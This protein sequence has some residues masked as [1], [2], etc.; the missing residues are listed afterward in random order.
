MRRLLAAVAA[1]AALLA[2]GVIRGAA[3]SPEPS[4]S[5][6]TTSSAAAPAAAATT[7]PVAPTS[8]TSSPASTGASTTPTPTPTPVEFPEGAP[9]PAAGDLTA[10]AVATAEMYVHAWSGTAGVTRQQWLDRQAPYT[11]P[12]F[13][14]RLATVD[15]ANVPAT[16]ITGPSA[17]AHVDDHFATVLVPTDGGRVAVAL[18]AVPPVWQV[19]GIEPAPAP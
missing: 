17:P 3:T 5:Q 12:Q 6:P 8:S 18:V 10:A 19:Y 14:D 7:R 11:T 9:P 13:L 4:A 16:E 15:L 2:F 1:V